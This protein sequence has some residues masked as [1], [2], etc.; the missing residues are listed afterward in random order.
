MLYSEEI[1]FTNHLVANS[2]TELLYL[3]SYVMEE[4]IA[5]PATKEHDGK[6]WDT[7]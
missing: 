3:L 6:D 4:G 7:S 5:R 2:R 1:V